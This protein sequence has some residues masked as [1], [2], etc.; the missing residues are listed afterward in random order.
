M[1]FRSRPSLSFPPND[2][3]INHCQNALQLQNESEWERYALEHLSKHMLIP[4][5]EHGNSDVLKR[6][7]YDNKHWNRQIEIFLEGIFVEN[8]TWFQIIFS[9]RSPD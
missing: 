6:V 8:I 3:I 7:A 5:F 2:S 9:V 1:N 4:A